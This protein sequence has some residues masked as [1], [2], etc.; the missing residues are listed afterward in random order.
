M[1]EP[2][3]MTEEELVLQQ[4]A[5]ARER[6]EA[7]R[8]A[9]PTGREVSLAITKLEEAEMWLKKRILSQAERVG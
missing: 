3:Q 4:I 2:R 6:L 8:A 5:E 1:F 7:H 9:G